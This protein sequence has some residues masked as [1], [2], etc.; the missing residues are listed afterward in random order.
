LKL[1]LG[2]PSGILTFSLTITITAT[3][4]RRKPLRAVQKNGNKK[5]V[6]VDEKKKFVSDIKQE[7]LTFER[8][9]NYF[10]KTK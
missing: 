1:T 3:A 4:T 5:T 8:F 7:L 2:L 6:F 10:V 9:T